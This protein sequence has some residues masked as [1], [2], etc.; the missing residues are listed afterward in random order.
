MS[1]CFNFSLLNHFAFDFESFLN[2]FSN[3]GVASFHSFMNLRIKDLGFDSNPLNSLFLDELVQAFMA[4]TDSL[5]NTVFQLVSFNKI[6]VFLTEPRNIWEENV[7][8]I[9]LFFSL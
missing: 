2:N 4:K 8:N 1:N 7:F 6:V 9:I 3:F 5:S